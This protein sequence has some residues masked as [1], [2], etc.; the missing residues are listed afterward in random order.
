MEPRGESERQLILECDALLKR[1][2]E[3]EA[4]LKPFVAAM[5]QFEAD[6]KRLGLLNPSAVVVP[7]ADC[8]RAAV[9][10]GEY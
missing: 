6:A 9:V 3:L 4:A 10:L 8:R 2:A 5:R 1:V 7:V